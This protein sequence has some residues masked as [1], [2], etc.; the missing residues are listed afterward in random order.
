M[1]TTQ[2]NTSQT[3]KILNKIL[4]ALPPKKAKTSKKIK[5]QYNFPNDKHNNVDLAIGA[6]ILAK[7]MSNVYKRLQKEINQYLINQ[8]AKLWIDNK[9]QPSTSTWFASHGS[10]DCVITSKISYNE[11]KKEMMS[12]LGIDISNYVETNTLEINLLALNKNS[13]AKEAFAKMLQNI[14]P[15]ERQEIVFPKTKFSPTLL[16]NL[17]NLCHYNEE[18]LKNALQ[19][20]QPEIHWNNCSTTEKDHDILQTV[21]EIS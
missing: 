16:N 10:F 19:V 12:D 14:S 6:S 7:K 2:R 20:L 21:N 9:Q 1:T 3:S 5:E 18:T 17:G 8:Y 13:K 15:E 4:H 11:T